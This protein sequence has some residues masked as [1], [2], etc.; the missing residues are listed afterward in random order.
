MFVLRWFCFMPVFP[1][2]FDG[3]KTILSLDTELKQL[4]NRMQTFKSHE[5]EPPCPSPGTIIHTIHRYIQLPFDSVSCIS[6]WHAGVCF[7]L[8]DFCNML[9]D[10]G[11]TYSPLHPLWCIVH[12]IIINRI[13]HKRTETLIQGFSP[14]LFVLAKL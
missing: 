1:G 9:Y 11:A 14:F 6:A 7:N 12:C 2:G 8:C 10:S 4:K 3:S 5:S 13:S